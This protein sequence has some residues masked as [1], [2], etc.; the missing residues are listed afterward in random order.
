MSR[1]ALVVGIN[2][3]RYLQALQSPAH[4]AEAIAQVLQTYGE[5][6]VQR[7]P[8]IV[9][10]EQPHIGKTTPVTLRT[11]ETALVNLFKPKGRNIPHTALF[12]FSGHGIQKDAGIQEGYLAVSD[13]QPDAGFY[14]LSLFWLRRLLQESPVRQRI[15]ILDCCHSGELGNPP[16]INLQSERSPLTLLRENVTIM[17][18]SLSTQV[19]LESGGHGLFSQALID[20]LNGGAADHF[21]EISTASIYAYVDRRFGA[22]Q[23]RP[24]YKAHSSKMNVLR[25]VQPLIATADLLQIKELFSS[26]DYKYPMDP[27]YEPEDEHGNKHEPVNEAKFEITRLFK[28]YRDAGLL[29]SS[30]STLQLYWV[31]RTSSTVELTPKGRECWWLVANKKI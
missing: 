20:A 11:L 26:P 2:T 10:S 4:D 24:V 19:S 25:K 7:L 3:Y 14:G 28:K 23:Q 22:W 5:F 21:G 17:A 30:D 31:A 8:E 13:A 6:R 1:D 27:E 29:K 12:Y 9:Q 18:A 16:S 15:V